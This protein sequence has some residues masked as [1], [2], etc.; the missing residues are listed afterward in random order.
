MPVI[1]T[2]ACVC[3]A[4]VGIP[5]GVMDAVLDEVCVCVCQRAM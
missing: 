1:A 5:E 2:S 3:F 4:Q